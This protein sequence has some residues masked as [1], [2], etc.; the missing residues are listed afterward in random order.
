MDINDTVMKASTGNLETGT[1]DSESPEID[2]NVV[3]ASDSNEH[4]HIPSAGAARNIM[5][6]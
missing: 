2:H 6:K 1:P 3:R 5:D 4:N